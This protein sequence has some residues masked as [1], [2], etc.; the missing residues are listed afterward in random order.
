MT[1]IFILNKPRLCSCFKKNNK[2]NIYDFLPDISKL[3]IPFLLDFRSE[4]L[5]IAGE[6]SDLMRNLRKSKLKKI[7]FVKAKSNRFEFDKFKKRESNIFFEGKRYSFT[8]ED[9]QNYGKV[10]RMRFIL[11]QEPY[12]FINKLMILN[13]AKPLIIKRIAIGPLIMGKLPP[14]GYRPLSTAEIRKIE[15]SINV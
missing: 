13:N 1:K 6:D 14:G 10:F 4:G 15:D 3:K 8:V 7:Y 5:I 2:Q 12:G 9:F 11:S